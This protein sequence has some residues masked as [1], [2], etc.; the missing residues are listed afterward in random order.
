M[1]AGPPGTLLGHWDPLIATRVSP[2][3][4]TLL[5]SPPDF[6]L[7]FLPVSPLKSKTGCQ[8]GALGDGKLNVGFRYGSSEGFF[9]NFLR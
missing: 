8:K 4:Q 3:P 1:C 5:I 2:G 7:F 6:S 9:F